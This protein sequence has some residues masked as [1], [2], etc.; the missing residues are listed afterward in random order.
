MGAVVPGMSENDHATPSGKVE[1]REYIPKPVRMVFE[2]LGERTETRC[3]IVMYLFDVGKASKGKI[4]DELA[5]ESEKLKT[6]LNA[7]QR[8]GVIEKRVGERIGEK[9]TGDYTTANMAEVVFDGIA[10]EMWNRGDKEND[11]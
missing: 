5:V 4:E 7:L 8:A 6:D 1:Y 9:E 10:S 2:S 3:A 11:Q